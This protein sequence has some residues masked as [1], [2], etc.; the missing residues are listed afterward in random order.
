MP[1]ATETNPYASPSESVHGPPPIPRWLSWALVLNAVLLAIPA[2]I[3]IAAFLWVL[4]ATTYEDN[5]LTG[6]PILHQ[7]N[8]WIQ[9]DYMPLIIYFAIPNLILAVAYISWNIR[10]RHFGDGV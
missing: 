10:K 6:D 5:V 4:S 7:H 3:L 2:L 8:F 1:D 9:V